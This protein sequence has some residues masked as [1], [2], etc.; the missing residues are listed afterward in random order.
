MKHY[1][2]TNE[3]EPVPQVCCHLRHIAK[4]INFTGISPPPLHQDRATHSDSLHEDGKMT[5]RHI[6]GIRCYRYHLYDTT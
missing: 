2:G 1:T 4:M 5:G 3:N 6:Y